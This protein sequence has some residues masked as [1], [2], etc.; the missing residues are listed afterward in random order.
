[1]RIMELYGGGTGGGAARYLGDLLPALAGLG[2]EVHYVSLGRDDLQ[3]RGAERHR[4]QGFSQLLRLARRLRPDVLH[5]HGV[6]ANFRGR[7]CGRFLGVPVATTVHSFLAQDYRSPARAALALQVD[8]A[9]LHWSDRLIAIS[10]AL[11]EDLIDRGAFADSVRV[12]PNGADPPPP[13]PEGLRGLLP[14]EDGPLLCVAARLHPTKGIDVALSALTH[15]PTARLAILGEGTE[16]GA[17]EHLARRL[18]VAERAYFVGYRKDFAAIVAGADLFLVPSRAEGFGLAALEAMGQG[19]PV[20]ASRV[21]GL[22]EV[23]GDAGAFASPGDPAALAAAV[24]EALQNH[25]A[26]AQ[27]AR[28][29]AAL[30][31]VSRM[32]EATVWVLREATEVRR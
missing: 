32:A 6:R 20:A 18:G 31:T 25:A 19:V 4:T 12:V 22:P 9:T 23:V 5:T 30:F 14:P 28:D 21:G 7:L 27:R 11:R 24:Q 26:L 15:L 16:R 17:L 2:H 13:D 10:G 8:G 1:M 3:P 29:R